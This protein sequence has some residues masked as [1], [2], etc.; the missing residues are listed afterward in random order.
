MFSGVLCMFLSFVV[1]HDDMY[2]MLTYGDTS[3]CYI[4]HGSEEE[5]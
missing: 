1:S 3:G 4:F 2:H 5:K